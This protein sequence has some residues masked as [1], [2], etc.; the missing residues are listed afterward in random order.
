MWFYAPFVASVGFAVCCVCLGIGWWV[1]AP[2]LDARASGATAIARTIRGGPALGA[3]SVGLGL[4]F[5]G[6]DYLGTIGLVGQESAG[7]FATG[8]DGP[9]VAV[10]Q[11][12]PGNALGAVCISAGLLGF[13]APVVAAAV[14]QYRG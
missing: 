5:I 10:G 13:L 12:V 11:A 7:E 1:G 3:S 14:E 4:V 2:R 6:L 9:L 8:P